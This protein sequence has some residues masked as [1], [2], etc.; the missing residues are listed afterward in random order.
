MKKAILLSA[1]LG[2]RLRP[3]TESIPKC[4][5]PINGVPLLAIWLEQL[6]AAGVT[7]FLINTHYLAHK[8]VSFL[9]RFES[10]ASITLVHEPTLL[11]TL[12]TLR[13][14]SEFW[15]GGDV[16]VVHADN[17]CVCNWAGFFNAYNQKPDNC[18]GTMMVFETD[19]PS[20][21]GVVELDAKQRLIQFHEKVDSPPSR[22]ANAAIY[23]FDERLF[24]IVTDVSE[25]ET[26]ISRDLIPRLLGQ[27]NT[28]RND[29]YM[30][31]IGTPES[32]SQACF[33]FSDEG[34]FSI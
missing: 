20:S 31:D 6:E 12:G 7:E 27:I 25:I 11:G 13:H 29:G 18:L 32:Y 14:N 21:C 34:Q 19:N 3:L 16:L 9:E 26:D 10:P 4:L 23:L 17:L 1:G 24:S 28:W 5:V 8:V 30:R 2:S 22:L 15:A 33:D